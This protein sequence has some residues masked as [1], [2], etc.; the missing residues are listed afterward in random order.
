MRYWTLASVEPPSDRGGLD[1]PASH[2]LHLQVPV[3]APA[4]LR[5]GQSGSDFMFTSHLCAPVTSFTACFA[6]PNLRMAATEALVRKK[7]APL[8]NQVARTH[9]GRTF[10]VEV[11]ASALVAFVM[12]ASQSMKTQH[13]CFSTMF[14]YTAAFFGRNTP[15]KEVLRIRGGHIRE[16]APP[17]D[18]E[19]RSSTYD[20]S[21]RELN[22]KD[23]N[24]NGGAS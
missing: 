6:I 11:V 12:S 16:A 18:R 22:L 7:S 5:A 1:P 24:R 23:G 4:P 21:A 14:P 15:M 2:R 19:S 8:A 3:K 10:S 13:A 9:G 17:R 20:I